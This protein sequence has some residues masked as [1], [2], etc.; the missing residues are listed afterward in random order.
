MSA[1]SWLIRHWSSVFLRL[2]TGSVF[3]VSAAAVTAFVL[4]GRWL[5]ARSKRSAKQSLTALLEVGA[6]QAILLVDGR[7]VTVPA[8]ALA[9]GE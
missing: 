9:V 2:I 6:K 3:S 8:G 7:E 5:E 1:A 4:L